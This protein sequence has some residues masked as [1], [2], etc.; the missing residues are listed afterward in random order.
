M[1]DLSATLESLPGLPSPYPAYGRAVLSALIPR[2]QPPCVL[3]ELR[4]QVT[5]VRPDPERLAAYREVCG[6]APSGHLPITYPQVLAM[7]MHLHLLSWPQFPLPLFGLVHVANVI[8][9]HRPLPADQPL[10][11]EAWIGESR[12]VRHGLAF[13]L[14]TRASVDGRCHWSAVTTILQVRHR[15]GGSSRVR[16]STARRGR[17]RPFEAPVDIG[18]RYAGVSGD[19]NPIHLS[20][21]TA[22]LFG[23]RRAIAHGMWT[24]ARCLALLPEVDTG[25]V[26]RL[27]AE[28]K[29]PLFLPS[30]AKLHWRD[31]GRPRR[32]TLIGEGGEVH[33]LGALR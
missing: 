11:L 22:R 2:G 8:D 16:S 5:G 28:F 13:D 33:L 25:A 6:L 29:Q 19:Y 31:T 3:P 10:D 26:A 21:V 12:L 18:R 24:L 15:A 7:G 1:V 27:T 17:H 4:T 14:L 32:F 30:R 23:F 20:A 9:Q